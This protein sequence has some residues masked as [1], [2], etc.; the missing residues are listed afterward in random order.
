[1]KRK[2]VNLANAAAKTNTGGDYRHYARRLFAAREAD[3]GILPVRAAAAEP[4]KTN[5][6]NRKMLALANAAAKTDIGNDYMPHNHQPGLY[7]SCQRTVRGR[8][9]DC[10]EKQM[11]R[12]NGGPGCR[13]SR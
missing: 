1:M 7:T 11:Y 8:C 6:M 5:D 13:L 4:V 9:R 3:A 2:R 10:C 12:H